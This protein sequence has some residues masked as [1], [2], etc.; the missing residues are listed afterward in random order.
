MRVTSPSFHSQATQCGST[1]VRVGSSI[2]GARAYKASS[3]AADAANEAKAA[4]A[5]EGAEAAGGGGGASGPG[6]DGGA[7]GLEE[8]A[9][10]G[11]GEASLTLTQ[12][13]S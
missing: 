3:A 2:F 11:G 5:G 7:S 4:A 8:G 12:S 13:G 9:A 6:G 1:N 10:A